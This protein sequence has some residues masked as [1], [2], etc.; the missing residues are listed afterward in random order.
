[1]NKGGLVWLFIVGFSLLTLLPNPTKGAVVFPLGWVINQVNTYAS[2]LS[3]T[4]TYNSEGG[5]SGFV[6][7]LMEQ[8]DLPE[9]GEELQYNY[10]IQKFIGVALAVNL[11]DCAKYEITTYF[12]GQD[13][14]AYQGLSQQQYYEAQNYVD[15]V[16]QAALPVFSQTNQNVFGG[17]CVNMNTIQSAASGVAS[18]LTSWSDS[19]EPQYIIEYLDGAVGTASNFGSLLLNDQLMQELFGTT[20]V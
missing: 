19:Y 5:F 16:L 7:N 1:M 15:T 14:F 8:I 6:E 4:I 18:I 13:P 11:F 17:P 20:V 12:E 3:G 2:Y 9:F 10:V